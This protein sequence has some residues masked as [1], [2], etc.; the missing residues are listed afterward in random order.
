MKIKRITPLAMAI[1]VAVSCAFSV[2]AQ[3]PAT[4]NGTQRSITADNAPAAVDNSR[5]ARPEAATL[6][7]EKSD[8]STLNDGS[9]ASVKSEVTSSP[10]P[11]P[12]PSSDEWHFKF[13]PYFWIAGVSGKAGIGDLVVNV[14]SSL[15][16]S[17]VHLNFG[18]MGTMEARRD[19]LIILTDLQY[20]NIGTERP[21][22]GILFSSATAEFKTFILDP[23]VGY[24]VA[25]NVEKGRSV[26]ILGG[27][28]YW[29]LRTDLDFA[30]GVLAARSA[31][32][33]RGWVDAIAGVRGRMSLTPKLFIVGKGD[34]GGGGAKV[35]YQLA[36][37]VGYQISKSIA[38]VGGYRWIH[39]N[40]DKDN[41]LFD[42]SLSG[43]IAGLTFIIK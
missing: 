39:V 27:I 36:G 4:S 32:A 22:P 35:D 15:G 2:A 38:L 18:F 8:S 42:N 14:D 20:S 3:T 25:E 41:F 10:N 12:A 31:T 34:V 11:A 33:S 9:P 29:H 13:T 23:E 6:P 24:R 1:S 40:Y 26:D 28:R 43:P 17:N 19:K 5:S 21:N 16:D 30:A 37:L 7:S